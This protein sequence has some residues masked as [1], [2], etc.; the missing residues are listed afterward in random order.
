[1]RVNVSFRGEVLESDEVSISDQL[2]L[3]LRVVLHLFVPLLEDKVVVLVLVR[4]G[5]HLLLL[6]TNT[7][8]VEVVVGV[9]VATTGPGDRRLK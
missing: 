2:H 5:G 1:M 4:V 7:L 6:G 9:E 8:G 3:G